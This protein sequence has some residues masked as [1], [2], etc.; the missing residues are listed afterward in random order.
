MNDW[1]PM[2]P[3]PGRSTGPTE[4]AGRQAGGATP[5]PPASTGRPPAPSPAPSPARAAPTR[6][7]VR[8]RPDLV[9]CRD[10][11]GT[12]LVRAGQGWTVTTTALLVGTA[13]PAG[14]RASGRFFPERS[15]AGQLT[16]MVP[17]PVAPVTQPC[18]RCAGIGWVIAAAPGPGPQVWSA[19][20]GG[21]RNGEA[22][23]PGRLTG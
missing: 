7:A 17:F 4:D 11:T 15:G 21:G 18:G 5:R 13:K 1:K 2:T 19:S 8:P 3:V 16:R 12:G 20:Y 10:C 9:P 22:G 14:D 6:P 23:L